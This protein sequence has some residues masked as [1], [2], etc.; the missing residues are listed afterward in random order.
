MLAYIVRRIL[1]M[2]PTLIGI[3]LILF[4]MARFAPGLTGGMSYGQGGARSSKED[5]E[6]AIKSQLKKLNMLDENGNMIPLPKQYITWLWN[7]CH[8]EFGESVKYNEK[9]SSL[10]VEKAPVTLAMNA[11]ETFIVYLIA[12]PGGMLAAVKRGKIFDSAWSFIYDCPL[13]RFPPFGWAA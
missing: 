13:F 3:T 1:L 11:I 8:L 4:L 6:Q 2:F 9:V 5:R 12:I 7:A 10:I